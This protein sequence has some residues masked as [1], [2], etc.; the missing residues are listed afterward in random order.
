MSRE[1]HALDDIDRRFGEPSRNR[2][3]SLVE[4]A[5]LYRG[6]TGREAAAFLRRDVHNVVPGSGVPKVDLLLRLARALDWP[7]SVV[8]DEVC[9]DAAA[10]K[11]P[12]A[13]GAGGFDDLNQLAY[14][15]FADGRF[16]ELIALARS[17]SVA[18][19]SPDERATA[20]LREHGGWDGL[21]RYEQA[22]A[23]LQRGLA[24]VE[25]NEELKLRL[26]AIL[27]SALLALGCW[28]EG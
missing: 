10:A 24:E 2:L 27:S 1:Q 13:A 18:A 3:R 11:G 26:R 9:G 16:E 8:L 4:F 17:M 15:A 6:W 12:A 20:C 19:N 28:T 7:A 25:V 23:S 21:G 22:V 5:Q 14:A